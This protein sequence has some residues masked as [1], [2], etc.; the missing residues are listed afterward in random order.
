MNTFRLSTSFFILAWCM[1]CCNCSNKTIAEVYKPT[2]DC[3]SDAC[4]L[5]FPV[6]EPDKI[7]FLHMLKT[8]GTTLDLLLTCFSYHHKVS[9]FAPE[10]KIK[11]PRKNKNNMI[12]TIF[13]DPVPRVLSHYGHHAV[14]NGVGCWGTSADINVQGMKKYLTNCKEASNLMTTYMKHA[15]VQTLEDTFHY[16]PTLEEFDMFLI[17]LHLR[18][19][20]SV[21]E[22]IN[23]DMKSRNS[24]FAGR[25]RE[26]D[27]AQIRTRN[28]V[29]ISWYEKAERSW[30]GVV[31]QQLYGQYSENYDIIQQLLSEYRDLK[32]AFG[33]FALTEQTCKNSRVRH[34]ARTGPGV[35]TSK[36]SLQR[37]TTVRSAVE[38]VLECRNKFCATDPRC[39]DNSMLRGAERGG[40]VASKV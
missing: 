27:I 36:I 13:R 4:L 37:N 8:G 19:N 28:K 32:H 17:L 30:N 1:Q 23:F 38:T 3:N 40:G 35:G 21:A 11:L 33:I 9:V 15:A 2:S 29:D 31:Q 39:S 24:S 12:I 25:A 10:S 22:I 5:G 14:G 26:D 16:T 20:F 6:S 7:Y 18:H 34:F